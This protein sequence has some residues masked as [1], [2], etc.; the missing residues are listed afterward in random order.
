MEENLQINQ[1]ETAAYIEFFSKKIYGSEFFYP[2]SPD[3]QTI[4][5][6]IKKPTLT[7]EHLK[8]CK[9]A[10]WNVKQKI[11]PNIQKKVEI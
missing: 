3:A 10:G 2:C 1:S 4:C 9:D 5:K 7:L 6:L 11:I 8:I